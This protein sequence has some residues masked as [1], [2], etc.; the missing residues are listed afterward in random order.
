MNPI[1]KALQDLRFNIPLPILEKAFLKRPVP[2]ALNATSLEYR[3]R[4]EVIVGRVL[5]DTDLIG[6][7]T[8]LIQLTSLIPQIWD[9]FTAVYKV[10]KHLTQNRTITSILN[11]SYGDYS[12]S[13]ALNNGQQYNSA[14]L[15]A[16]QAVLASNTPIPVIS[17]ANVDIIG[18]N[19]LLIR[20][21]V[22][23]PSNTYLRCM[24][25]SD[26]N[27]SHISPTSIPAFSKLVLLATKAYIYNSLVIDIDMAE[28]HGGVA[29]GRFKEIIDGYAD[30]NELY[31][32]HRN[33]VWRRVMQF[34]DPQTAS[35]YH[36]AVM[37]GRF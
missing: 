11:V 34:N 1:I 32:I 24:I 4:T 6:G 12:Y 10:P 26:E 13:A 22:F 3:I 30:A 16:T 37:G 14:M 9:Q 19:T 27:L 5:P 20:D 36:K 31:E 21:N 33:T 2:A 23:I 35:R 28:L 17:T 25:G 7:S 8:V 15:D 29:L 18:D